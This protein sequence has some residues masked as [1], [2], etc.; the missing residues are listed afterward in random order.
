MSPT[1]YRAIAGR[2]ELRPLPARA[3]ARLRRRRAAPTRVVRAWQEGAGPPGARRLRPDRDGPPDWHADQPAEVRPGSMG[4]PLPGFRVWVDEG[5]LV[6]DPATVPTFFLDGTRDRPWRTGDRVSGDGDGYFLVPGPH[7]RR[8]H[9]LRLSHWPLRGG[10]GAGGPP[11]VVEAAAVAART[12][13]A[14]RWC[15]PW[16]CCARRGCEPGDELAREL[17]DHEGDRR[18]P[19]ST[20]ASSTS[21][22]SSRRP[23]AARSGERRCARWRPVRSHAQPNGSSATR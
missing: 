13:S 16:S 3:A 5:E 20:P 21:S 7:R 10:V 18:P 11:A 14:A 17:Q 4:Q 9:L 12:R 2:A 22:P 15:A 6:I 23:R 1:E 19:T 8:D